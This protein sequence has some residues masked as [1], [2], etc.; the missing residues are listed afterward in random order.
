MAIAE[1]VRWGSIFSEYSCSGLFPLKN[2][3]ILLTKQNTTQVLFV[4]WRGKKLIPITTHPGFCIQIRTYYFLAISCTTRWCLDKRLTSK[5]VMP[6]P[7]EGS[8]CHSLLFTIQM[9]FWI[10]YLYLVPKSRFPYLE[11]DSYFSGTYTKVE[12]GGNQ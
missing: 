7:S 5:L 11:S 8:V 10:P 2:A 9:W 4:D 1:V 6:P 12:V 3:F